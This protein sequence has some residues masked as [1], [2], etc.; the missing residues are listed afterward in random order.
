MPIITLNPSTDP[1]WAEF[2]HVHKR[3]SLFHAPAWFSALQRTYGYGP[4]AFATQAPD[5]RLS[6]GVPFCEVRSPLT[7][8]R[9]VSLPFSDHCDPLVESG[10][11]LRAL[12]DH[13]LAYARE[14]GLGRV[15]IRPLDVFDTTL[16]EGFG[17]EEEFAFHVLDLQPGIGE[18]E[19][20]FHKTAVRQP[21]GRAGREGLVYQTGNSAELLDDF[22]RLLVMTRRKHGL[23]PQPKRWFR[24]LLDALAENTTI[25]TASKDGTVIAAILTARWGNTYYYKYGASDA[26]HANL[27][28]TALLL[29]KTI[30]EA[31][32]NGASRLDMGRTDP[33]NAGLAAFKER[34]GA[35][36][37]SLRYFRWPAPGSA[38]D[39]GEGWKMRSVKRVFAALPDWALIR[40]GS[41]LYRHM[42]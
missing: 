2:V 31:K 30:E 14:H 29:W 18:I 34:W 16:P 12:L 11:E 1:R 7:G 20:R 4:V 27:G 26:Q 40:A 38:P 3:A 35:E 6:A 28:G 39:H 36:R 37:R 8:K 9:L 13:A 15:Q 24:A 22:F 32:A 23:P 33:S 41:L 25:R 42:G 19:S 10:E 17:P 21:I 5:G